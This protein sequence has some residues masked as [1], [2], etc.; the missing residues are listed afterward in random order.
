MIHEPEFYETKITK[1]GAAFVAQVGMKGLLSYMWLA[2]PM[3]FC[4]PWWYEGT[5]FSPRHKVF[6]APWFFLQLPSTLGNVVQL[7]RRA[8]PINNCPIYW[9][10][11]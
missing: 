1:S 11:G 5:M 4:T 9:L 10:Y 7:S 8:I 2:C 3:T 6:L